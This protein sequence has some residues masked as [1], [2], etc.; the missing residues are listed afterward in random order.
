MPF[1]SL[2]SSRRCL[3]RLRQTAHA[4]HDTED[5]VV[6]GIQAEEEWVCLVGVCTKITRTLS[7]TRTR[8][9][10]KDKC[11]VVDAGE[12]ART[13]RLVVLGLDRKRVDVD[14]V[15]KTR[16]L[17][18]NIARRTILQTT[19]ATRTTRRRELGLRVLLVG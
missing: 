7:L 1:Y 17:A 14:R 2:R 4:R 18:H 9:A 15:V 10:V 5:V 3:V 6:D 8:H 12:V 19:G 13:R 16:T 11:G